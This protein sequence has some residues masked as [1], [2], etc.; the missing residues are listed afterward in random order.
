MKKYLSLLLIASLPL[1]AL[2][3]EDLVWDSE[4]T[5]AIE[6]NNALQNALANKDW[7]AAIDYADAL[8]YNF[9]TTPF[10]QELP[11]FSGYSYFQLGQYELA[12]KSLSAYLNHST[13]HSHFEEA[14]RMKFEIAEG[15]L[16]GKKKRLFGSHKMPAWLPAKEDAL[17]L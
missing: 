15:Y 4:N 9:P 12:N 8:A 1:F 10:A 11:Y 13:S 5:S 17:E 14:I 16:N 6:F 7:W 2:E 3:E